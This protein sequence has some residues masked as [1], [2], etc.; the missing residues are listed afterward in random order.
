M[1]EW[2][3]EDVIGAAPGSCFLGRC[4][5]R[6]GERSGEGVVLGMSYLETLL[7]SDLADG[8]VEAQSNCRVASGSARFKN[9]T[10]RVCG[11]NSITSSL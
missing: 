5:G 4:G 7:E 3:A 8:D 9:R 2:V 10:R 11:E 1:F 6:G